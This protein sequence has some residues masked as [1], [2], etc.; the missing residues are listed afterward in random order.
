[1]RDHSMVLLLLPHRGRSK[2]WKKNFIWESTQLSEK[3]SAQNYSQEE[4]VKIAKILQYERHRIRG[5]GNNG[6]E[7]LQVET[8]WDCRY[9]SDSLLILMFYTCTQILH[10]KKIKSVSYYMWLTAHCCSLK[11]ST[12]LCA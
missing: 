9:F 8:L 7:S 6:G 5:C 11:D 2:R 3:Y 12:S 4:H 10:R 1:M